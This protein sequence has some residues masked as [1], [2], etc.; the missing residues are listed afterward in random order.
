MSKQANRILLL[1]LGAGICGLV[2]NLLPYTLRDGVHLYWGG[3]FAV[4]AALA[5]GPVEGMLA[6]VLSQL[7]AQWM[8]EHWISLVSAVAEAALAGLVIRRG[9]CWPL[10]EGVFGVALASSLASIGFHFALNV[11]PALVW[12]ALLK[13]PLEALLHVSAAVLLLNLAGDREWLGERLE[14]GHVRTIR[15]QLLSAVIVAVVAPFGFLTMEHGK[16]LESAENTQMRRRL[17]EL[18]QQCVREIDD[19]IALHRAGI[20]LAAAAF[21]DG[22]AADARKTQEVLARHSQIYSG[23]LTMLYADEAGRIRAAHPMF[24]RDGKRITAL[25]IAV[26]DRDYFQTPKETGKPYVSEVFQGKGFG[27]DPI[28]AVSAPLR[29]GQGRFAGVL[30][31]SL[32]LEQ[33]LDWAEDLERREGVL[34]LLLD[35]HANT[36]FASPSLG[37]PFLGLVG[38]AKLEELRDGRIH[39]SGS[40]HVESRNWQLILLRPTGQVLDAIAIRYRQTSLWTLTAIL[41]AMI[42]VHLAAHFV[43][44]P[45][46]W[47]IEKMRAMPMDAPQPVQIQLPRGAPREI[48]G[49]AQNLE[50][51]SAGLAESYRGV[52]ESLDERMRLNEELTRL[53]GELKQKASDLAQAKLRAE[54]ANRAKTAFLTNISHE[55]RTPMNGLMGMLAILQDGALNDDQ[56]RRVQM[57]QESASSLLAL[58][59][60]MLTFSPGEGGGTEVERVEF[61]PGTLVEG[62]FN[63]YHHRAADRGVQMSLYIDPPARELHLGDPTR[64]SQV[65]TQMVNNSIK[66]TQRGSI[67]VAVV[68]KEHRTDGADFRF[69]VSDTGIGVPEQVQGHIFE[70]FTQADASLT[71][72]H[73][74]T[75]IGLAVCKKIVTAL[76]GSIGLRS[77][78]NIGSVFWFQIPL[79][80]SRKNDA[81]PEDTQTAPSAPAVSRKPRVLIVEDNA[82]NQKVASRLVERGGFDYAIADNGIAALEQLERSSFDAVL[83]D[84]QMP[85]MDGYQATAAIRRKEKGGAHIPIIAM[86]AHAMEGDR[87]RC[88]EAGM[89]DYLTK[90]VNRQELISALERWIQRSGNGVTAVGAGT[91]PHLPTPTTP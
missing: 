13:S 15:L 89:D 80:R 29:D 57:A 79:S 1:S 81:A 43:H 58:M 76:G 39:L 17:D 25:G 61:V 84:C 20:T 85:Q 51:M 60:D 65:L 28:I 62:I 33:F 82:V 47:V 3:I 2:C 50:I 72:K 54:E 5:L 66:F 35:R 27:N 71:R 37:L 14:L 34:S 36:I 8:E 23:I 19:Y 21:E 45:L 26:T 75:G 31:G 48:E 12:A 73:G 77:T 11:H 4:M 56:H 41:L 64:I 68:R 83:M 49:L 6:A 46:E 18:S 16:Q 55:I 87:E 32:N 67:R 22:I 88:L 69:E 30:E 7:P 10:G 70:P 78:E 40:A 44:G 42:L 9:K 53:F 38:K 59:N 91:S 74:G 24:D 63:T 86:T 52:R 90:P